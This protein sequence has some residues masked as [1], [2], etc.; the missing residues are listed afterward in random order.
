MNSLD[1]IASIG[2]G[3]FLITVVFKGNTYKL[4]ERMQS[5]KDFLKW[6][7]ALAA[8]YYLYGIPELRGTI[9]L[10]ITVAILA[11][12]LNIAGSQNFATFKSGFASL[13]NSI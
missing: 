4:L 13:W 8:L 11:F 9:G 2:V 5:D 6:A 3:A 7:I 10:L 12:F 1:L